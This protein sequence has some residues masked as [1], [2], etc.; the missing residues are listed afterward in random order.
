MLGGSAVFFSYSASFFTGVRLA[1]VI[2][3]DWPQHHTDMLRERKIDTA[4]LQVISG[5]KTF[6]WSGRYL[7]NMNDRETISLNLN[8]MAEFDPVPARALSRL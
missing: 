2:G 3:E 6:R 1:G 4:G 7:T 5:G 8:V